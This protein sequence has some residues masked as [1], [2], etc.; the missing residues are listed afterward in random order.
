MSTDRREFLRWAGVSAGSMLLIGCD[1]AATQTNASAAAAKSDSAGSS[2]AKTTSTTPVAPTRASPPLS[3]TM[4]DLQTYLQTNA[5]P[6]F[7]LPTA[8]T[9]LPRISWAGGLSATSLAAT[10]LPSGVIFPAS[11][12]LINGPIRNEFVATLPGNPTVV[13]YPCL[14]VRRAYTCKGQARTVSSPTVLRFKTDAPIF[15]LG[16]VIGDASPSGAVQTLIVDGQLVPPKVLSCGRVPGGGWDADAI[17]FDF[18]S[19]AVRDIWINTS[20]NVAY[21]KIGQYDTL[22][23]VDD[24][25]EPQITAVGD[26]YL[27]SPS[28]NFSTAAIAFE[29]GARLGIRNVAVDGVG[30]TGYWNSGGNVGNLNDRL[31]G[32]VAD[33]SMIYLIMAGLNDYGD[34]TYPPPAVVWPTRATFEN[35]VLG[36]LQ[37]LRAAQPNAL[38]V[39]TAPFCPDPPMSDSSYVA[40]S[41]TNSSGLGD[42]LYMAQVHKNAVQQIAAPWVYID[43]LM[44]GGWLNSSGATGDITNL[45]WFTGGT[46]G[47]GTTATYKPGNTLGGGGGGFGGIVSVPVISGGRYSQAPDI[48]ASGGSG[49]GLLLASSVDSTGAITSINIVASGSG[50]TSGSG[51]PTIRIDPTYQIIPASLDSPS[52]MVGVNP[53][54]GYPLPSFAPPGT[55]GDLNNIYVM[56]MPDLTHPSPDGVE[57]LSSRLAQ[58]IFDAVMAL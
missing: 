13:G 38:I 7:D 24:Q 54:G 14:A 16:G 10:S 44:G 33:N 23:P 11:S 51:L 22:F 15:E 34:Y 48:T 52:L 3:A 29:I 19:R 21:I 36:Y 42:F 25:S 32:H 57:Y 6:T 55:P 31:P 2:A 26:S 58:N 4:S 41:M 49:S 9:T 39:V 27:Q 37:K 1:G 40:N 47:A 53:D 45:Q 30:G 5:S 46:P 50:Y 18:G 28:A 20:L 56:L 12:P 43:V 17:Q 35:A 8:A